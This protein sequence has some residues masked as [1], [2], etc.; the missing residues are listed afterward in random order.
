MSE[1]RFIAFELGGRCHQEIT[2]VEVMPRDWKPI[3]M[4]NTKTNKQ[5]LLTTL[6]IDK[7]DLPDE[8]I[9]QLFLRE[10]DYKRMFGA[11]DSEPYIKERDEN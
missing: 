4:F 10:L 6:K 2:L 9:K 7:A 3:Q 5:L 11:M 8:R 1:E